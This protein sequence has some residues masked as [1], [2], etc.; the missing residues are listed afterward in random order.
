MGTLVEALCGEVFPVTKTAEAR[1]P[2]VPG[3]QGDLR[4]AAEVAGAAVRPLAG[5]ARDA[6][7]RASVGSPQ[8]QALASESSFA[9][10]GAAAASRAGGAGRASA[11]WIVALSSAPSRIAIPKKKQ[12]SRAAIGV[13]S[14][15]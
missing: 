13:A 14:A 9:G 10:A 15:P 11:A 5:S 1:Q 12:N 7:G 3:L 8:A 4:V 6:T 2:G